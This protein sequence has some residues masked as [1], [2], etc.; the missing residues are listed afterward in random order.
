MTTDDIIYA[1]ALSKHRDNEVLRHDAHDGNNVQR[2]VEKI[3]KEI[4]L[5][6]SSYSKIS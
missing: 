3:N 4:G 2:A 6:T 1:D 5:S